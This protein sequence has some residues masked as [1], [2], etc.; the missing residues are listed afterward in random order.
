VAVKVLISR[1]SNC[2]ELFH[3]APPA[4]TSTKKKSKVLIVNKEAKC[5]HP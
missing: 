2:K 5:G 4:S 1:C 3:A